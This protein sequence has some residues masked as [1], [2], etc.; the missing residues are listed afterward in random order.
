MLAEVDHRVGAEAVGEPGIGGEIGG[1]RRQRG[2]VIGRLRVEIVAARR[3]DQHRDVAEA[4]AGDRE[5]AAIEPSRPEE[6][7]AFGRSPLRRNPLL[8]RTRQAGEEGRILGEGQGFLGRRVRARVAGA[9]K[10]ARHQR[11]AVRGHLAGAVAGIA[12][13]AQ[14]RHR[15][16]RRVEAD[17]VADAAVAVGVVGQ[18]DGDAALGRR[19]RAQPR[20]VARKVGDEGHPVGDRAVADEVGFGLGVAAERLLERDGARQDAA[21]DLGQGDVHRQVAGAEAARAVAPRRLVAAGKHDLQHRA[22][23]LQRV[24]SACCRRPKSRWH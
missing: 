17:A 1:R 22:I 18:H 20:P 12:Q 23:G 10:Q 16:L 24:M 19:L 7:V 8:H 5:M 9:G 2:I 4:K 21:V 14:Q 3:L 13:G 15:R 11:C 6:R